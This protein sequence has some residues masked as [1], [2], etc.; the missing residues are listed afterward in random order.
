VYNARRY[1]AF[2]I[3][4]WVYRYYLDGHVDPIAIAAGS[5]QTLL[6]ADFFYLYV[7]K[8]VL[9]VFCAR[10]H[11]HPPL[12]VCIASTSSHLLGCR[13][14]VQ[15]AHT[16]HGICTCLQSCGGERTSSCRELNVIASTNAK[17]KP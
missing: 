1:R 6:Y 15:V 10:L 3:C 9:L 8:G 17:F 7:T 4:N 5:L 2:Y 14:P 13:I 16:H 11:A 12:I